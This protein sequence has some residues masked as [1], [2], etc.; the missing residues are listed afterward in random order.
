MPGVGS[1]DSCPGRNGF[2][3]ALFAVEG[4]AKVQVKSDRLCLGQGAGFLA[5]VKAL[6][7]ESCR[8]VRTQTTPRLAN[9]SMQAQAATTQGR[10]M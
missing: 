10:G 6:M 4:Q 1:G 5:S 9:R 7:A 2:A 3:K 8:T